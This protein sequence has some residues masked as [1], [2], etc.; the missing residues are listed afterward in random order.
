MRLLQ[1]KI[2]ST[3]ALPVAVVQGPR[4]APGTTDRAKLHSTEYTLTI[5]THLQ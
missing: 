5:H 1:I 4:G 3:E 2:G